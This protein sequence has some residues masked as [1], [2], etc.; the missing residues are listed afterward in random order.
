MFVNR[1]TK[2][3]KPFLVMSKQHRF[4]CPRGQLLLLQTRSVQYGNQLT[5]AHVMSEVHVE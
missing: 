5:V 1:Q 4:A 2:N 3:V